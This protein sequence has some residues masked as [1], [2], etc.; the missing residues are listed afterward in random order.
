MPKIKI[1]D[2][3]QAPADTTKFHFEGRNPF[4]VFDM[5]RG[6]LRDVMK[7]SSK[8]ILETDVR[9]D[10]FADPRA[11]YGMWMGKRKE[12]RWTMTNIRIILQG[13]I[14]M[15]TRAG[16]LDA[17]FKGTVDTEYEYHNFIQKGFW[18]QYNRFFYYGQ[19][20]KYIDYAND[21]IRDI[22][23]KMMEALGIAPDTHA[24][25]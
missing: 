14:S 19:R 24:R 10:V 8:D 7:I 18:W 5:V 1:Y 21:N 9:W 22:R 15:K 12:D 13:E 20:R 6:L 25:V 17:R 23:R 2:D 4:R 3:I 11:F 16:W